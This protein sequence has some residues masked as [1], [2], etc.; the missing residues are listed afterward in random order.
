MLERAKGDKHEE[1]VCA[2]D[3]LTAALR[4]LQGLDAARLAAMQAAAWARA[5]LFDWRHG[6]LLLDGVYARLL[7][8]LRPQRVPAP[9]EPP[10]EAM[11][12]PLRAVDAA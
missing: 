3:G 5:E 11:K 6:G 1:S 9:A 4:R 8:A 2:A 10:V 7:A 12:Q